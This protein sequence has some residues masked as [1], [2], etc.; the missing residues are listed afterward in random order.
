M[1]VRLN[2]AVPPPA[3]FAPAD[4]SARPH[5]IP[6]HFPGEPDVQFAPASP[7]RTDREHLI[8]KSVLLAVLAG[9]FLFLMP[10]AC[11]TASVYRAE[12]ASPHTA[13]VPF[14]PPSSPVAEGLPIHW[15]EESSVG[16][17]MLATGEFKSAAQ[18]FEEAAKDERRPLG[19]RIEAR[20]GQAEAL[21]QQG[22]KEDALAVLNTLRRLP[23]APPPWRRA[24]EAQADKLEAPLSRL[25]E[26]L[27]LTAPRDIP[28][29]DAALRIVIDKSDHVLQVYEGDQP[30][31]AFP[32]GLGQG[33]RTPEGDF[34]IGNKLRDPDWHHDGRVVKAG[35][36]ENP[37]GDRWM[38]LERGGKAT[39]YGIHPT[40]ENGSIGQDKSRGCVRM[41]PEDAEELFRRC[42]VG[43]PVRICP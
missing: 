16:E 22:R 32:V 24:A 23:S 34:R 33:G 19:E 5:L 15:T 4:H 35:D 3:G 6:R 18:W 17:R 8:P 41:Y 21:S 11:R 7:V 31:A 30:V 37:L 28:P 2:T 38:G 14:V 26:P 43:T 36:P 13:E 1:G 12:E 42:P 27:P 9:C 29:G 39:P 10:K 20:M 40:G 25:R